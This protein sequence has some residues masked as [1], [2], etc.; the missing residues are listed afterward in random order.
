MPSR[1]RTVDMTP[2]FPNAPVDGLV[3]HSCTVHR[4]QE[5]KNKGGVR[6]T[7]LATTVR[8]SMVGIHGSLSLKTREN[9]RETPGWCMQ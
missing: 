8:A 3:A 2:R 9:Q 7:I 6:Q 1:Y 5:R 4:Q